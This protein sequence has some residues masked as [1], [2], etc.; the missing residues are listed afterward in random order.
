MSD[1]WEEWENDDFV[2]NVLNVPTEEQLKRLQEQKIIEDSEID[3][4]RDLIL[5]NKNEKEEDLA[6]EEL[7]NLRQTTKFTQITNISIEIK[8]KNNPKKT[9]NKQK[10]NETKQKELSKKLKQEKAIKQ[11]AKEIFGEAEENYEYAEYE[12]MFY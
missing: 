12:D 3:L 9:N 8:K 1:N 6:I 11:K 4:A 10:E 5:N 7:K 2:I